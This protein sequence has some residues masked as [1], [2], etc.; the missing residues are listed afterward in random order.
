[1]SN[2]SDEMLMAYA[3]GE[4]PEAD[5]VRVRAYLANSPEGARRLNAFTRT[6]R[7]LGLL[8]DQP[9]HE[10]V[11][12]RLLDVVRP[13]AAPFMGATANRPAPKVSYAAL[14]VAMLFPQ[15]APWSAATAAFAILALGGITGW[16][17]HGVKSDAPPTASIASLIDGALLTN[18]EFTRALDSTPGGQTNNL[19]GDTAKASVKPVLTFQN[20]AGD[21]CRQYELSTDT[22]ARFAG[23]G[24]RLQS[25]QWRIEVH[26]PIA[27]GATSAPGGFAPASGRSSPT[28]EGAIDRMIKGDVLS[29]E[30][31]KALIENQWRQQH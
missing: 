13:P 7:D 14:L 12:Q 29:N 22:A 21:Y 6:G 16:S 26:A 15:T 30:A 3:D 31:E 20:L 4:L 5:L 9:M 10:A 18:R 19:G 17:L 1:M 25:G 27:G 2:I 11:P 8:Y 24:C 23:V 28:V